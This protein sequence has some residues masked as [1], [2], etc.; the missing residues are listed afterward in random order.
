VNNDKRDILNGKPIDGPAY[1]AWQH[2]P[3]RSQVWLIAV[4]WGMIAAGALL[5]AVMVGLALS[6]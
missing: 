6:K 1:P 5:S 4:G 3:P 2:Q